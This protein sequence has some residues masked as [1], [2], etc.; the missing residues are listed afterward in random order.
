MSTAIAEPNLVRY[1]LISRAGEVILHIKFYFFL[2][3]VGQ[4]R[5]GLS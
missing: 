3:R 1:S 2:Y 5:R 4:P